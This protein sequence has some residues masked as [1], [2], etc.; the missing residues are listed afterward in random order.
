MKSPFFS[1][2]SFALTHWT[3]KRVIVDP[4]DDSKILVCGS[5]GET[6]LKRRCPHQ[7]GPL[8]QGYFQG[9]DLICPWHGCRF[10]LARHPRSAKTAP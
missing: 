5:G 10:R 9:D 2:V 8:E 6:S 3:L 7:G 1:R 4:A